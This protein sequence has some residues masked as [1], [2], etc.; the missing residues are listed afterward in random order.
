MGGNVS[1]LGN[2]FEDVAVKAPCRAATTANIV[3][4]GLQTVDTVALAE[5]DRVLV[6]KQTDTTTN[7]I[8]QASSGNWIRTADASKNTDFVTG[9]MVFITGGAAN[10]SQIFEM[11]TADAPVVIGTS[12]LVFAPFFSVAVIQ[13]EFINGTFLTFLDSHG[14]QLIAPV[15]LLGAEGP[16]GAARYF[17]T[18]AQ[19]QGSVIDPTLAFITIARYATASLLAPATYVV[20]GTVLPFTDAGGT[21][22]GI[23]V[24]GPFDIR[25][26]G[27]GAGNGA[28]DV[29][30]FNAAMASS[31]TP[32]IRIPAGTTIDLS[33]GSFLFTNYGSWIVGDE[34]RSSI[35]LFNPATAAALFTWYKAGDLG[36]GIYGCGISD[37]T[38]SSSNAVAKTIFTVIN[39]SFFQI[40]RC[41]LLNISDPAGQSIGLVYK[42]RNWLTVSDCNFECDNP[43]F[44]S[45][46]PERAAWGLEDGDYL[47]FERNQLAC[48]AAA[49]GCYQVGDGCN[50][51]NWSD[52]DSDW[53][54][55]RYGVLNTD[56]TASLTSYTWRFTGIR[57]E[58]EQGVG[59]TVFAIQRSVEPL[60][61]L[62]IEDCYTGS[63]LFDLSGVERVDI[64]D[65]TVSINNIPLGIADATVARLKWS[66][67]FCQA[68]NTVSLAGQTL[69]RGRE[70]MGGTTIAPIYCD[71]TYTNAPEGTIEWIGAPSASNNRLGLWRASANV[72][73]F[74]GANQF[75]LLPWSLY[76]VQLAEIR[77]MAPGINGIATF[78]IGQTPPNGCAVLVG[79]TNFAVDGA[80][81]H[82]SVFHFDDTSVGIVNHLAGSAPVAVEVLFTI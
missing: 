44:L 32:V 42:G 60:R 19:A 77:V 53:A 7:G 10:G 2:I 35:I 80:A 81:G 5:G 71:A 11:R 18:R 45:L 52:T 48:L 29:A 79:Q 38:I 34:Q 37:V 25:W 67:L 40:R 1:R 13:P 31:A 43:V 3:L 82:L 66:N 68:G 49:A 69:V 23:N 22:W 50:I 14:N 47:T 28:A 59:P 8:Y 39:S 30:A 78:V 51:T 16:S 76:A 56:S 57:R 26:A 17:L 36:G 12:L 63:T 15:N 6:W 72:P 54:L 75:N 73:V 55:G 58:Q 62:H 24:S 64:V 46:N 27:G 61:D 20:N 4:S 70:M 65:S 9:T 33:S 74:T 21:V 41:L